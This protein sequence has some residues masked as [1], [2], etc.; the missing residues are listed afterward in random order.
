MITLPLSDADWATELRLVL[1]L[2][3]YI[4]T[5]LSQDFQWFVHLRYY[6]F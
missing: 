3:Y 5:R 6:G 2:G 4:G 1:G